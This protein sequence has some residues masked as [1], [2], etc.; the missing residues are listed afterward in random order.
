[1]FRLCLRHQ[2]ALASTDKT[3]GKI[4]LQFKATMTLHNWHVKFRPTQMLQ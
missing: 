3:H 1:M 4:N 2:V